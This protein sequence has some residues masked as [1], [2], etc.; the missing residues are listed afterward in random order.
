[1]H[2]KSYVVDGSLLRT[3]SANWSPTG[4]KRQDNDVHYEIDTNWQ[5]CSKLVLKPYGIALRIEWRR[6]LR[7]REGCRVSGGLVSSLPAARGIQED[8]VANFRDKALGP[9]RV[10][11]QSSQNLRISAKVGIAAPMQARTE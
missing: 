2:F 3:G 6:P 10:A 1:M 9:D 4:L 5:R 7:S 11:R 8:F